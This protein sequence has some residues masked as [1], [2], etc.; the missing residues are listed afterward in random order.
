MN[1]YDK[2]HFNKD[3]F[4]TGFAEAILMSD[5]ESVNQKQA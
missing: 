2:I 3:L 5:F 1:L 4:Y